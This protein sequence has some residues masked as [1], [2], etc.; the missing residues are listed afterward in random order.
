M[1]H[2]P[3]SYFLSNPQ[4]LGFDIGE[5]W[6]VRKD[7]SAG[8]TKNDSKKFVQLYTSKSYE[9]HR[10]NLVNPNADDDTPM[11]ENSKQTAAE[12]AKDVSKHILSPQLVDAISASTQVVWS[13]STSLNGL[14]GRSDM[15]L[16]TAVG[17]P[18]AVDSEGNMC[19]V[20]MYG[21]ERMESNGERME[22]LQSIFSFASEN[23]GGCMPLIKNEDE[24][25]KSSTSIVSNTPADEGITT[26]FISLRKP[27]RRTLSHSNLSILNQPNQTSSLSSSLTSPS[28]VE[29]THVHTLSAAPKDKFGIPMLPKSAEVDES[30]TDPQIPGMI[31][32]EESSE[33]GSQSPESETTEMFSMSCETAPTGFE[34]FRT[35]NATGTAEK[36]EGAIGRCYA[37]GDPVWEIGEG[38]FDKSRFELL[39]KA[40]VNTIMAV[41]IHSTIAVG[42]PSFV[43]AFYSRDAVEAISGCLRFVQQ[44]VKMVWSGNDV[45]VSSS[46]NDIGEMAGDMELQQQFSKKRSHDTLSAM[47]GL[48]MSGGGGL[49][50][51]SQAEEWI[52]KSETT[53]AQ[54][55]VR[56]Q[57]AR[58]RRGHMS[59]ITERMYGSSSSSGG[60]QLSGAIDTLPQHVISEDDTF[61]ANAVFSEPAGLSLDS[62]QHGL[63]LSQHSL[64]SSQH[65]RRKSGDQNTENM[66]PFFYQSPPSNAGLDPLDATYHGNSSLNFTNSFTFDPGL[67]LESSYHGHDS[68]YMTHTTYTTT[69]IVRDPAP[70]NY[71]GS[72]GIDQFNYDPPPPPIERKTKPKATGRR[73][74]NPKNS[75]GATKACRILG[76][77]ALAANRRPYCVKHSGSRQCEHASGCSKCAQGSTRFCIAHGGGRRCTFI[78]CD[79]GARDKFFCAAHGGGKRCSVDGCSKSAVGGSAQCTSHGGGKRC[80][81]AGCE[82]SAQSST[83]FCVRHGGGKKCA[84]ES[85]EGKRCDKVARGRTDFCASHGGGIRCKLEACNRVAIGK[86]QLCRSHGQQQP[87]IGLIGGNFCLPLGMN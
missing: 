77:D 64:D 47:E 67:N 59:S 70:V 68:S 76:C 83:N 41:P 57:A 74:S 21:A 43:I 8:S 24:L 50:V 31:K 79:K 65:K 85:A 1:I 40:D 72:N 11:S 15:K 39:K 58:Q 4:F 45:P 3:R 73:R 63:N 36:W 56:Q 5:V 32:S 33:T 30:E 53:T 38:E 61:D 17:M 35:L 27:M 86:L 9:L 20:V 34:V 10:S 81:V 71:F 51:Q 84:H 28:G 29:I 66:Q 6:W 69:P 82:K 19:V 14:L 44:A 75:A 22:Y 18:V 46:Y 12:E 80:K 2:S 48:Q 42:P 16:H 23:M 52:V 54:N 78:G 55:F 26:H 13:T 60:L 7:G 37:T 62:S 87:K 25:D 49:G